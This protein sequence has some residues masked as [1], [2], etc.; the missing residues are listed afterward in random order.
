MKGSTRAVAAIGAG[1]VLGRRRK[2]RTA[3][4]VAATAA[5]GSTSIGGMVLKRG[6]KL[7]SSTGVLNA[8]PSEITEIVDTVRGDL[9][10]AG[11][12]AASAAATSRVDALTDS[13]HDRAERL[14]DPA[15]FASD[16]AETAKD[17]AGRAT[18]DAT[19]KAG[20]TTRDATEKAGR[21]TRRGTRKA[22]REPEPEEEPTD[23]EPEEP[24]AAAEPEDRD[25]DSDQPD[26]ADDK[27]A[28][29]RRTG[30]QRRAAVTRAGR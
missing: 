18:G 6:A 13:L 26:E 19:E 2:L 12:A 3:A 11:K 4:M 7:L 30:T 8:V 16:T 15:A 14:R 24:E 5:V 27:P 22:A 1:Y 25:D 21:A 23:E 29:V 28:R 20:R 17:E 9:L 10:P